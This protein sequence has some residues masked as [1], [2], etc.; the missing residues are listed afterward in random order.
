MDNYYI[1]LQFEFNV[2]KNMFMYDVVVLFESESDVSCLYN[3][4]Y[5][6]IVY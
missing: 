5:V 3:I 4:V 2:N 1:S 6:H